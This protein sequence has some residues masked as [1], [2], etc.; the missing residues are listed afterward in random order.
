MRNRTAT[1]LLGLLISLSSAAAGDWTEL[2]NGKDL[3]GWQQ[4][5][6]SAPYSVEGDAI[7]GTAV[8]N[9]PNSFLATEADYG[10][11]IL[12]FEV[13]MDLDKPF[14]SGVQFRSLS[15]PEYRNGRVHGYQCEIDPSAGRQSGGIYDEARRGWLYPGSF[16]PASQDA[17][18]T[19][20]WNHYRIEAIGS[21]L[22]TWVNGQPVAYVI[23]ERT[24]QGFIALQVHSISADSG[25]EGGKVKWR[26]LRIQ[27]EDLEPSPPTP[28][29]FV[30]NLLPNQLEPEESAR[31]WRL[32]WDGKSSAGWRSRHGESFPEKGWSMENGILSV[33]E[34]SQ[35]KS[36]R[37]GDIVTE[38]AFANFELQLEYRF[39]RGGNSG[40]FY[41]D[42]TEAQLPK[43]PPVALEYQILDD[44]NHA[45]ALKGVDG[46]RKNA[47]LYDL[48]P[49][50]QPRPARP[51]RW[52]HALI[53]VRGA[54]V[55]HW[56]SGFRV[57][58]YDRSSQSFQDLV[59]ASKFAE[60]DGFGQWPAG[61]IR[62]QDHTDFVSFRSIKIRELP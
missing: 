51:N 13:F 23:D 6:G 60:M 61:R 58:S 16:N 38:D 26:K 22:R 56:L 52:Y 20:E 43:K 24:A 40:I 7:V 53:I 2:F 17:F 25:L 47:S 55:E 31:G 15:L 42:Q 49:S 10:D 14:N 34:T 54:E 46:N 1:L 44:A 37:G 5:N 50:R 27:T 32:L 3:D 45:D 33:M 36:L 62:L 48:I 11:F 30:R 8:L 4:L 9:S 12:E 18:Q 29:V 39:A 21:R 41:L 19:G 59:A 35:D 57:L 28:D